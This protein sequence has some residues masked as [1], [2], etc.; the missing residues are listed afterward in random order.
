MLRQ[1]VHLHH[2]HHPL[3]DDDDDIDDNDHYHLYYYSEPRHCCCCCYCCDGCCSQYHRQGNVP[4]HHLDHVSTPISYWT[5]RTN[6]HCFDYCGC[7]DSYCYY[8]RS[9]MCC[10]CHYH[11]ND[12]WIVTVRRTFV[13]DNQPM[14]RPS[15]GMRLTFWWNFVVVGTVIHSYS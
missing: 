4:T 9:M 10:Y 8:C 11:S 2:H 6:S 15:N 14:G 5:R 7:C 3:H 12:D 13:S 1:F